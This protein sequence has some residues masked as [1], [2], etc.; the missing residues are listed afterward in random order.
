MGFHG[1]SVVKNLPGNAG[2]ARDSCLITGLGRSP[3]VG[4]GY[5]LQYS[6][7]ENSIDRGAWRALV[8][9]VTKSDMIE[10]ARAHTHICTTSYIIQFCIHGEGLCVC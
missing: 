10:Q 9:G 5:P 7:L 8:H 3:G 2:D 1:D 4:N 6:C